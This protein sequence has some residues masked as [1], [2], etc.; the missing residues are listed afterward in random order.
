MKAIEFA[1]VIL[2]AA[3][4][5]GDREVDF[6]VAHECG[7]T[8]HAFDEAWMPAGSSRIRLILEEG[9]SHEHE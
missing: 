9:E 5:Y 1:R 8:V 7:D 2:E 6:V 3:E 4:R